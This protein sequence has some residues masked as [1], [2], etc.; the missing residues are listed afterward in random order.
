MEPK[1]HSCCKGKSSEPLSPLL[2][3]PFSGGVHGGND[4]IWLTFASRCEAFGVRSGL[5]HRKRQGDLGVISGFG[6]GG[7]LCIWYLVKL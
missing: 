6:I 5:Q 2:C 1:D 3:F 4:P 7:P